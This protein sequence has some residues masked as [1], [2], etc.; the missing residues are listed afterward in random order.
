MAVRSGDRAG[1]LGELGDLPEKFRWFG[2]GP[3]PGFA[4]CLGVTSRDL[5]PRSL[6]F[7]THRTEMVTHRG[8]GA[9]PA[10]VGAQCPRGDSHCQWSVFCPRIG[11]EPTPRRGSSS[12]ALSS[13]SPVPS[14]HVVE[15]ASKCPR[16]GDPSRCLA[17]SPA[18]TRWP[19]PG[20]A[21]GQGARRAPEPGCRA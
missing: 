18:H 7:P 16:V 11:W 1:S 21:G 17:S 3:C 13:R 19:S 14:W 15:E 6:S 20:A 12:S 8:G 5:A 4:F 10:Q 2:N 9:F